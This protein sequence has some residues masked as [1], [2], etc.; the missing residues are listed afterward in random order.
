MLGIADTIIGVFGETL[1]KFLPDQNKKL[2]ALAEV[3]AKILEN[4]AKILAIA[5]DIVGK[6]TVSERWYQNAWRPAL[7]WIIIVI[8]F[9]NFLLAPYVGMIFGYDL[10]LDVDVN[11]LP[12][13]LWRAIDIG[14]GG[15]VIGRSAEKIVK[16]LK[17]KK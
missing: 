11:S 2:E 17:K 3:R 15:Y 10:S 13:E 9:N 5:G 8:I 4:E 16:D 14:L 7:M 12:E 1:N 6:E